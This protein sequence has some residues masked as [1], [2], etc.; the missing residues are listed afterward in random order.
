MPCLGSARRNAEKHA[1]QIETGQIEL[2]PGFREIRESTRQN[3]RERIVPL[4][5]RCAT[6]YHCYRRIRQQATAGGCR[7]RTRTR[8]HHPD[9]CVPVFIAIVTAIGLWALVRRY[10]SLLGTTQ[11]AP[12]W[13]SLATLLAVGAVVFWL[14]LRPAGPSWASQA[15]YA[16]GVVSFCPVMALLGAKRPQDTAWQFVVG[17]LLVVLLLP[18]AEVLIYRPGAEIEL[19]PARGWFLWILVGLGLFNAIATR[20]AL[21]ALLAMTAQVLLLA[22]Q[23]PL[24]ADRFAPRPVLALSLLVG[25]VV[26]WS[27]DPWRPRQ[28]DWDRAWR[29]FRD[30]FGTLWSLR[31]AERFNA[32]AQ[33][34]G[35]DVQLSWSG[36]VASRSEGEFQAGPV[37]LSEAMQVTL[38]GL[39]RRFVSTAWLRYRVDCTV[40]EANLD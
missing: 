25:A 12:W 35:W 34:H 40:G 18:S 31:V 1:A 36:F 19:H 22:A 6:H 16:A 8:T 11:T 32:A 38:W 29:D 2:R 9:T 5:Q 33:Q 30:S 37:Q 21:A 24:V 17:T 15:L 20:H 39:W 23:L 7:G 13:W 28:R 27:I 4:T 10:T 26:L 14:T 3:R